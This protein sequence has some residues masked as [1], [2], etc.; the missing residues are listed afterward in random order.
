MQ[1]FIGYVQ[2]KKLAG[3]WRGLEFVGFAFRRRLFFGFV[4][5]EHVGDVRRQTN[6][7]KGIGL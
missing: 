2:L 3:T 5:F 4:R 7:R 1:R 6:L